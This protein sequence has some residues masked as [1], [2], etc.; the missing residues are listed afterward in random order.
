MVS[1]FFLQSMDGD[2]IHGG[3]CGAVPHHIPFMPGHR[4]NRKRQRPDVEAHLLQTRI[5]EWLGEQ[6]GGTPR[7]SDGSVSS[8]TTNTESHR[9]QGLQREIDSVVEGVQMRAFSLRVP[10]FAALGRDVAVHCILDSCSLGDRWAA[11]TRCL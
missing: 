8:A 4:R 3:R 1:P 10:P 11:C 5:Q 7:V 6:Y 9:R 2:L